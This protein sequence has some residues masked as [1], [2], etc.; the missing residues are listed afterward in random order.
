M[1]EFTTS[2]FTGG[3]LIMLKNHWSSYMPLVRLEMLGI[4]DVLKNLQI[5][6]ILTSGS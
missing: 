2:V 6:D 5:L 3:I 1:S 4:S